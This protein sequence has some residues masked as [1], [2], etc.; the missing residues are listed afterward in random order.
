MTIPRTSW[1]WLFAPLWLKLLAVAILLTSCSTQKDTFAQVTGS[2]GGLL[3]GMS[4]PKPPPPKSTT[5]PKYSGIV[6]Q[7][8]PNGQIV[9]NEYLNG[10]LLSQTWFSSL[11]LPE[12]VINYIDGQLVGGIT[13]FGPDGKVTTRT[14][15]YV[16]TTQPERIEDFSGGE[17]IVRFTTY[18]PNGNKRIVSET[19]VAPTIGMAISSDSGLV[20]RIQEW[21]V[22]GRPK[23]LVQ[24]HVERDKQG[25][26][27][28]EEKQGRQT[29]WNEAGYRDS[30]LEYDHG[31]WVY[32]Y[33]AQKK[34]TPPAL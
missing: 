19:D 2:H 32:D 10:Q 12:K 28:Y 15:Y 26:V 17:K 5:P 7:V 24:I 22:N 21:Y 18:W 14:Y 34:N 31:R 16:G 27:L 1:K 30:D 11:H 9:A 3:P 23:S 20:N 8:Q 29:V 33:L 13:E 4:V 6:Q 25:Q